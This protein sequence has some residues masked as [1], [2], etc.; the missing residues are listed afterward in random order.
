MST[1]HDPTRTHA[2]MPWHCNWHDSHTLA[3]KR[4]KLVPVGRTHDLTEPI[5]PT[6]TS[7]HPGGCTSITPKALPGV[8][9][10][11]CYRSPYGMA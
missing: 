9:R 3:S 1:T 5:A 6:N 8:R 7:N 2:N 11:D 10:P 4:V